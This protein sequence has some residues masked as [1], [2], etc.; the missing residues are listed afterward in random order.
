MRVASTYERFFSARSL[1]HRPVWPTILGGL[2]L[3]ASIAVLVMLIVACAR[4]HPRT[5]GPFWFW[6]G[7]SALAVILVAWQWWRKLFFIFTAIVLALLLVLIIGF[8]EIVNQ[9]DQL[10]NARSTEQFAAILLGRTEHVAAATQLK[11]LAWTV[12][13]PSDATPPSP[14]LGTPIGVA[15]SALRWDL[16]RVL[17]TSL[18]KPRLLTT[19]NYDQVLL[20]SALIT[21]RSTPGSNTQPMPA[22]DP[23]GLS[24]RWWSYFDTATDQLETLCH[25]LKPPSDRLRWLCAAGL[26]K[27][28]FM[29]DGQGVHI[30]RFGASQSAHR[31]KADHNALTPTQV[32]QAVASTLSAVSAAIDDLQK[33]TS[34]DQQLMKDEKNLAS[35][36]ESPPKSSINIAGAISSGVSALV[37]NSEGAAPGSSFWF[38]PLDLGAWIVLAVLL[39]IG[40]RFLI[41][42]NNRNGWGPIEFTF[43]STTPNEKPSDVDA[44]RLAKIRSYVVVNIPEPAAAMGSNAITQ[45]TSLVAAAPLGAPGWLRALANFAQWALAPPSGYRVFATFRSAGTPAGALQDVVLRIETRGRSKALEVASFSA[46]KVQTISQVTVK[47]RRLASSRT[48]A[49]PSTG[50]DPNAEDDTLR[51]A[52][53]WVA[54]WILSHCKL[55]PAWSSWD[56]SAAEDL[57]KFQAQIDNNASVYQT[58]PDDPKRRDAIHKNIELLEEARM[59]DPGSGFVLTKLAEWYEF[60]D[61]YVNALELNLQVVRMYPRYYVARYRAAIGL[62]MM[63]SAG[64]D[65]EWL[66]AINRADGQYLRII[67]LLR[68]I[69]LK[70]PDQ[71]TDALNRLAESS[72][73]V[74]TA[75]VSGILYGQITKDL[76]FLA[77]DQL[78]KAIHMAS[79][80][81]MFA[82][83]LRKD[84]R[85]FWL[86]RMRRPVLIN[87]NLSSAMPSI[88]QV[89][90]PGNVKPAALP[91]EEY[92]LD[93]ELLDRWTE[94]PTESAQVF[95]NAACFYA[96]RRV[97]RQ[98]S[99]L[100]AMR[101]LEASQTQPYAEEIHGSWMD[102]DPDLAPLK[103][104]PEPIAD[105][106]ERLVCLTLDGAGGRA[107][108]AR[109]QP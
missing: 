73:A 35:A 5:A 103:S 10:R 77:V 23:S 18:A 54:G 40:L 20:T 38:V 8:G 102:R 108:S 17:Q 78:Y 30:Q 106:F 21:A 7:F 6:V 9:Q 51:S 80:P 68:Q 29:P 85:R 70:G 2:A 37:S 92:W 87:H 88:W 99:L 39:F 82:M 22:I 15:S 55:V 27:K 28:V 58:G 44:Q 24:V 11:A 67:E 79:L 41:V 43:D 4:G 74:A 47:G 50:A 84:E 12:T 100:K 60:L 65:R 62:S 59:K 31:L 90:E 95:Y 91:N 1:R 72:N 69:D 56:A 76:T 26:S 96:N 101:L 98:D 109:G 57:G 105:R 3:G 61:D 52:G 34:H 32:D 63:V 33:S 16:Q 48:V 46:P 13:G 104:A 64:V 71:A 94:S 49:K 25:T 107:R 53:Y 81:A 86:N 42:L 19:I 93:P 14:P 36:Y 83:S 97:S 45:V 66:K 89:A 75:P